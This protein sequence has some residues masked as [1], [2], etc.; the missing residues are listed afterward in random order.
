MR[1]AGG[2]GEGAAAAREAGRGERVD[3]VAVFP[4]GGER[5]GE[6]SNQIAASES[7]VVVASTS[8]GRRTLATATEGLSCL[9]E[10]KRGKGNIL[11]SYLWPLFS[12]WWRIS[13]LC[14]L[15]LPPLTAVSLGL[16]VD[17]C[18]VGKALYITGSDIVGLGRMSGIVWLKEFT[19][20]QGGVFGWSDISG[21]RAVFT[22]A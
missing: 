4:Q 19:G 6:R 17:L 2:A 12:C 13:P 15:H 10:R 8:R 16:Q 21:S 7:H 9:G 1:G 18:G 3:V 20:G 14:G 5:E 11:S 22:M